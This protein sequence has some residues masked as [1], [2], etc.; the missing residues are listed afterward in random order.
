MH[1]FTWS[2]LVLVC[3]LALRTTKTVT[4]H[5]THDDF[6]LFAVTHF[7]AQP[8]E[9]SDF[10][11]FDVKSN[12]FEVIGN[13]GFAVTSLA[14]DSTTGVMYGLS[15]AWPEP[16]NLLTI[17]IETGKA[18]VV[19]GTNLN[20]NQGIGGFM[21]NSAG[22]LVG[23]LQ[24]N[25]SYGYPVQVDKKT[26][27]A[28]ALS[29][30]DVLVARV[31]IDQLLNGTYIIFGYL[32]AVGGEQI[33]PQPEI[34]GHIDPFT[35]DVQEIALLEDFMD[36]VFECS[37]ASHHGK[38]KPGTNDLYIMCNWPVDLP[39]GTAT[40]KVIDM[41]TL[42][43]KDVFWAQHK[44]HA[45]EFVPHD[46]GGKSM[47]KSSKGKKGKGKAKIPKGKGVTSTAKAP[48]KGKTTM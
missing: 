30:S 35:G 44:I 16:S 31:T 11:I 28:V 32:K 9:T 12:N 27:D 2:T 5:G 34:Y 24:V 1:K 17:D 41:D 47:G 45:I 23:F 48:K 42:E 33:F 40:G 38:F 36:L 7:S 10:G 14:Y 6:T 4:A 13:T 18:T 26:G 3:T 19:G 8:N 20:V 21:I 46:I 43:M 37:W 15:R 25:K 22:N 39:P 29:D